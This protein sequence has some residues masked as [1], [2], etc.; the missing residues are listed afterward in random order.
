MNNKSEGKFRLKC[1]FI[2]AAAL[3]SAAGLTPN[4]LVA[5]TLTALYTFTNSVHT[6]DANYGLVS[7]GNTLFGTVVQGGAAGAGM[8]FRINTD[9]TCFTN[10]H[11]FSATGAGYTNTGGAFPSAPMILSGNMLY[12]VTIFGGTGGNGVVFAMDTGGMNFT[13]LHDFSALIYDTNSDGA[14]PEGKLT[15]AGNTLYGTAYGGGPNFGGTLFSVKTDATGFTN[16][17]SF[18]S[19]DYGPESQLVFSSNKLYGAASFSEAG[20]G[21]IFEVNTDGTGYRDLYTFSMNSSDGNSDGAYP[22]GD[23]IIIGRTLYGTAS[24][25]GAGNGGTLFKVNIDNGSFAN[26][27]NFGASGQAAPA[28]GLFLQGNVLYGAESYGGSTGYGAVYKLNLNNSNFVT[29]CSFPAE[30]NKTNSD[31]DT[32]GADVTLIGNALYGTTGGGGITGDGTVFALTLPAPPAL[33]IT[34]SG[35]NVVL[36]WPSNAVGF[37]LQSATNL[38]TSAAWTTVSPQPVVVNSQNTVTN[39]FSGKQIFYRLSQ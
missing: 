25:G 27:H 7:S 18:S 31:G 4:P 17:Y 35:S 10:L 20:S 24:S 29:L 12:G 6:V 13:N 9:G 37:I 1:L 36:T 5:Q 2:I 34:P 15:L 21:A 16:F 8:I 33:A 39:P 3:T 23:L 14:S 28:G 19:P 26:L 32:P 38:G 22:A 11:N 30:S